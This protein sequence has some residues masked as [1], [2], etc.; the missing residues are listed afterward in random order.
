[1]PRGAI[2]QL[3]FDPRYVNPAIRGHISDSEWR[4]NLADALSTL[5]PNS[6]V[7]G[8]IL[9]T[10]A[11]SRLNTDLAALNLTSTFTH[12]LN[13]SE[14]GAIKPEREIYERG[15]ELCGC[16]AEEIVFIDD[17]ADNSLAANQLGMTAHQF[18]SASALEYFFSTVQFDSNG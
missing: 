18:I 15:I 13:S 8:V 10:N 12:V 1:L 14:L 17:S 5:H 3:A 16:A 9:I 11:T 7:N 6:P 4:S 2:Y